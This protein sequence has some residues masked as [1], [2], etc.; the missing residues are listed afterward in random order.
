MVLMASCSSFSSTRWGSVAETVN[1]ISLRVAHNSRRVQL[2][3]LGDL[4]LDIVIGR[5]SRIA[6]GSDVGGTIAF[7]V[8]GSAANT[9]RAFAALGG[10]ATF[11]GTV[12]ADAL[13]QRLVENVRAAGVRPIVTFVPGMATAQ[14]AVFV[15][16]DGER[17]FVTS[18]GAADCLTPEMVAEV[19]FER[20]DVLHLPAY[21][22]LNEPI[23]KAALAAVDAARSAGA[24]VSVDLASAEPLRAFGA[25]AARDAV[26][27]VA[28][29]VLFA[30][31]DEA[32]AIGGQLD[33]LSPTIVVKQGAR[34]C[35]VN[36]ELIPTDPMATVHT[37]GAGDA[38][39]AGFLFARFGD[40]AASLIDAARSGHAAAR[41]LL[42]GPRDEFSPW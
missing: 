11:V 35:V 13:G 39:D 31:G 40:P 22:L 26:A 12:G 30:N 15:G 9:A 23:G 34:G 21:S 14:I 16:P 25:Q 7:R 20:F 24:W 18:R 29:D 37:T 6:T 33:R 38:F 4:S 1:Q 2:I 8:G 5:S 10:P 3:T 36:G 27:A 32:A 42:S 28:P 19:H 41:A 17:S